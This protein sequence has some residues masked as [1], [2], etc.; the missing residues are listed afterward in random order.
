MVREAL[1]HLKQS[2]QARVINIT[3]TAVKEPI[4][5]LILSNSRAAG[6]DRP[7][8]DA[9]EGAGAATASP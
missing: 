2:D 9:V 8:E 4:D 5:G 7:R 3:S 6:H 1:P